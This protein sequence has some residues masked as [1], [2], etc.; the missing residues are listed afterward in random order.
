MATQLQT[1]RHLLRI[2]EVMART[3]LDR[4]AIYRL[5]RDGKFSKPIKISERS[6]AW[7]SEA[8]DSWIAE[9]IAASKAVA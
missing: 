6:S 7:D 2:R 4:S 5:A 1:A 3:G 9:R 8:V